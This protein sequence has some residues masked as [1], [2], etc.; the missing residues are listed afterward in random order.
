MVSGRS[1]NGAVHDDRPVAAVAGAR[2]GPFSDD[3]PHLAL[4]AWRASTTG[5]RLLALQGTVVIC[6]G[7]AL[8]VLSSRITLSARLVKLLE[9]LVFGLTAAYLSALSTSK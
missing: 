6:L 5:G 9:F 3:H 2:R 4:L 8:A 7:L 1:G